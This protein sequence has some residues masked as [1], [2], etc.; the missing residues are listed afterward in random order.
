FIQMLRSFDREYLETLWKLVKAKH[1]YT[2]PKEGYG[3]VLWGDLKIMFEHHVEDAGRIVGIKRLLDDLRVIAVK[4]LVT[5]A[6]NVST[7]RLV[8]LVQKLLLLVLKVNAA[9]IQDPLKWDQ[10]VVS[11]LV[12][13]RNFAKKTWIKTQY[14]WWLHQKCLCSNQAVVDVAEAVIG[15][16]TGVVGRVSGCRS[17]RLS[18]LCS[19][20]SLFC[21]TRCENSI[22]SSNFIATL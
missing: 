4:V 5:I 10:Q 3:R 8:L 12:A 19:C 13:L 20:A 16:V 21:D 22:T 1:G 11:E 17:N 6:S 18:A 15:H 7:A 9:G 2:R 14:I